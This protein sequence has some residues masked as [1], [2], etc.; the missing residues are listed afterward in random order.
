MPNTENRRKRQEFNISPK[1]LRKQRKRE[2]AINHPI[3]IILPIPDKS[4]ERFKSENVKLE[5]NKYNCISQNN[6]RCYD[7]QKNMIN[8]RVRQ[9]VMPILVVFGSEGESSTEIGSGS[10]TTE[11]EQ[12]ERAV[13]TEMADTKPAQERDNNAFRYEPTSWEE[14]FQEIVQENNW[15][16][17]YI[18]TDKVLY[19]KEDKEAKVYISVDIFINVQGNFKF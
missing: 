6:T 2:K 11:Q 16:K 19:K 7:E 10:M 17:H 3:S 4:K 5:N 15:I 8:N 1:S 14:R 18:D 13:I 12:W 9:N